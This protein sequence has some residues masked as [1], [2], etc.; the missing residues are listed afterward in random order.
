MK[1]EYK[2]FFAIPFDKLTRGAYAKI[3]QKLRKQ[4]N[5]HGIK[6]TII[7][8]NK[9]VGPSQKYLNVLSFKAQNEDLHAQ[10]L[11]DIE[12]AD[13]I[14]ADLTNNNPNVHVELGM[15]LVMNK[16]ILRVTGRQVEEL[17]FDIQNLE[18]YLYKNEND[19]SKKIQAYLA[20]FVKIKRLNFS[21]SY[22]KL[23]RK[24]SNFI[25]PLT[26][27]EVQASVLHTV[28]INNY[29]FKDGAIGFT[30]KFLDT[31]N[32][33]AWVGVYFRTVSVLPFVPNFL[34][35]VRKNGSVELVRYSLN[36]PNRDL[37]LRVISRK[38]CRPITGRS[39]LLVEIEN[40]SI[41]IKLN[42]QEFSFQN[43]DKQ[44]IG[45]IVVA[46][47]EC[48]AEIRDFELINRDTTNR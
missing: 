34:L 16:N 5:R 24:E 38:K 46:T 26:S 17:G 35:H 42:G 14:V 36:P 9:Q 32:D 33:N 1:S 15:A 30:F 23:Y 41:G 43:I 25:L 45:E 12:A 27:G 19:L 22:K 39:Y 29:Q 21:T 11:K 37:S 44:N 6:L 47:W 18:V 7:I 3:S 20:G 31:L 2:I 28:P 4:F 8:G 10:F 48:R 13:V 40:E